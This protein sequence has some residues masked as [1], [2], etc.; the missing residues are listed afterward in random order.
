MS[1]R[2]K[3]YG[4]FATCYLSIAKRHT[5]TAL[6]RQEAEN[7]NGD[8]EPMCS[9]NDF[10]TGS[11]LES[12]KPKVYYLP[13]PTRMERY[14]IFESIWMGATFASGPWLRR[15]WMTW[16]RGA[17]LYFQL[18]DSAVTAQSAIDSQR[19]SW[20]HR[21]LGKIS[22]WFFQKTWCGWNLL[23]NSSFQIISGKKN[24]TPKISQSCWKSMTSTFSLVSTT[25]GMSQPEGVNPI[26][27]TQVRRRRKK[28]EKSFQLYTY[29]KIA[30]PSPL[31]FWLIYQL[32]LWKQSRQR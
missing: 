12:N 17:R 4:L 7:S 31:S 24:P 11:A 29:S 26:S 21:K 13:G 10:Q 5:P 20:N 32:L 27:N 30:A 23:L 1:C 22:I 15:Y 18:P 3:K 6:F 16:Y 19:S 25:P 14:G 2:W 28:T 9:S 8:L